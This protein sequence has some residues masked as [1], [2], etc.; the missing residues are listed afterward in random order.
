M[1]ITFNE[2]KKSIQ[3]DEID[4][5]LVCVSDIQGRLNGKRVTGRAFLDYVHKETHMCDYLYTV[6]MDMFTVPGYQ[7]IFLGDWLW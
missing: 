7:V 5:I 4:T 3:K 2:L 6:D 1:T